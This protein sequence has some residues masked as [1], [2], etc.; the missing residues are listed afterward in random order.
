MHFA[1]TVNMSVSGSLLDAGGP[2]S[3][4]RSAR[5]FPMEWE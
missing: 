2:L 4:M 5:P 1:A 3:T